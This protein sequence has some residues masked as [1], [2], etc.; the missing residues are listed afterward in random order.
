MVDRVAVTRLSPLLEEAAAI[1]G[2]ADL[3]HLLRTLISEARQA[4][5]ARY[6]ALGVLGDHGVLSDF[7]Y[8]GIT[9]EQARLIGPPPTGRGV[10]GTLIHDSQPLMLDVIGEHPDSVGVPEHHPPMSTFLGVPITA[11]GESFGNLYLTEKEGGFTDDDLV[12]VQALS[13]IAGSAIQSARL[14]T[15][16]RQI[17]VVED[18]Q[19]IARDLHDS[20]IQDLFAVGLRLQA[21][22]V[23]VDE[24]V[25]AGLNSAIDTLDSS[26]SRLRQY[27][28]EL[29]DAPKPAQNLDERVREVVER[30]ARAY[31]TSVELTVDGAHLGPWVEDAILLTT[32][33]L[34]N[35]LRH[36]RADLIEVSLSLS[37]GYQII[38]VVDDGVGFD[39]TRI[40]TGMGLSSM[41][42]RADATGGWAEIHSEPGE[43]TRVTARLPISRA[44]SP[45]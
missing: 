16:L 20:V 13:H 2:A 29:R 17:A 24:D 22:S 34:S 40:G 37:E 41:K 21:L 26:V 43:G 8:D 6:A 35:A 5:G 1:G 42:A 18:R 7:L 36:G 19:R 45:S 44:D 9:E 28:F 38:E 15:R 32:E 31:P 14:Q 33:A 23:E 39:V 12:A 27:I 10:L 4:T 25:A 11:G 30:M 3:D